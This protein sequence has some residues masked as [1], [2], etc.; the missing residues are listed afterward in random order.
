MVCEQFVLSNFCFR[1][2]RWVCA[3]GMAFRITAYSLALWATALLAM[4]HRT[5]HFAF[6]FAALNL[7]FGAAELLHEKFRKTEVGLCSRS[8]RENNVLYKPGNVSSTWGVHR[9][10][11]KLGYKQGCHTSTGTSDGSHPVDK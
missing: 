11:R 3:L 8:L 1:T 4:F 7:A 10:A 6:R 9:L 5:A 2:Y